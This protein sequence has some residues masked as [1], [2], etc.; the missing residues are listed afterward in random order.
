MDTEQAR[1][2]LRANEVKA[3]ALLNLENAARMS[4]DDPR[5]KELLEEAGDAYAV[6]CVDLALADQAAVERGDS[7]IVERSSK[8]LARTDE[9]DAAIMAVPA[10]MAVPGEAPPPA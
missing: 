5:F 4:T 3:R 6:A 9:V 10:V 8:P 7:L 1:A 2:I